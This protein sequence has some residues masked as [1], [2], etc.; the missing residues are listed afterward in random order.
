MF[1]KVILWT[2]Y[3]F[4]VGMLVFGAANRTSAKTGQ[5]ILFGNWDDTVAG[6]GQGNESAGN[7]AGF[8]ENEADIHEEILD[9]QKWVS[10]SGQI[11]SIETEVLVIQTRTAGILEIEGRPL[12]FAQELG[13]VPEEGNEVVVQGF[14][15]NGEFEVSMIQD[16]TINQEFRLRD[17]YGRPMWGGGGRN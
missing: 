14:Y 9:E 8:D 5:G 2:V 1:K 13:Y 12:R 16:L 4:I 3:V 11:I 17:N 7:S 6:W 15:E 10:F